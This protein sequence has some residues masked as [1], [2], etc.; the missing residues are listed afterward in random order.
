MTKQT[1]RCFLCGKEKSEVNLLLK[2]KY[3]YVCDSCIQEAH[4][5]LNENEE[6]EISQNVQLATPRQI[7]E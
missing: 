2:G 5:I 6:E 3:G 4:D 7:K 1:E